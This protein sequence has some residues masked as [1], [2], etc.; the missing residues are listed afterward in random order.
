LH[1]AQRN[2]EV[3]RLTGRLAPEF[4]TIADFA[5]DSGPAVRATCRQCVMLCRQLD[6]FSEA[7]VEID[8]SKFKAVNK[9]FTWAAGCGCAQKRPG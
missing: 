3:M 7:I 8:S 4:K 5:K 9:N 1:E 6:L 2:V